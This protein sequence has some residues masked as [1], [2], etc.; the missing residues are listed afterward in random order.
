MNNDV[1]E[2]KSR[3]NLVDVVGDYVRLER[4]G[5]GQWKGLC[6]FHKERTPSFTVS[7]E[8]QLW[9]CFGCGK[10]GD[11]FSFVMEQE[12]VDF[13]E[14]LTLLAQRA[15][16]TLSRQHGGDSDTAPADKKKTYFD[17]LELATK[18]YQKQL[19]DGI[20]ARQARPYVVE[21][22]INEMSMAHFRLGFAPEGWRHIT[23]FLTSRGY[24]LADIAATGL[25]VRKD[26]TQGTRHSDY[27]D[28]FRNRIMFPITDPMG[29]VIGFSARIVPSAADAQG[30][31]AVAKYINTSESPVYHKSSVLYGIAQAKQAMKD[32]KRAVVV[33]GNMD[34]IAAHQ[35]GIAETVAVSGTALTEQHARIIRRYAPE[36]VLFFDNDTAGRAAAVK[37]T[38]TCVAV[39]LA[40]KMVT[41]EGDAKD[42]ADIARDDPDAL[43]RLVQSARNA[44]EVLFAQAR[45]T[46]DV[47][48]PDARSAL[49]RALAPLVAAHESRVDREYWAQQLAQHAQI[50]LTAAQEAVEHAR[51]DAQPR[52]RAVA[53]EE[54]DGAQGQAQTPQHTNRS[55]ALL[56]RVLSLAAQSDRAFAALLEQDIPVQFLTEHAALHA[57]M[58]AGATGASSY[59]SALSTIDD[60]TIAAALAHVMQTHNAEATEMVATATPEDLIK[61]VASL[62]R[63]M[64]DAWHKEQRTR[65]IAE[66][67]QAEA[68]G[69]HQRQKEIL[70][71]IQALMT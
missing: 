37:S 50:S 31:R 38:M 12:G 2:V 35:A 34:V 8:R 33:E 26:G 40:V 41:V 23:E 45:A 21:R 3:L 56:A 71:R 39:G 32:T 43:V 63:L 1:E 22:G 58:M 61:E 42:A 57:L 15:G 55:E 47:T 62:V 16:V 4:A 52:A 14:A 17:I 20:G 53:T 48:D 30:E 28:R 67:A 27:Y 18:F 29:H 11:V 59:A 64:V 60:R 51:T 44:L 25:I 13:R 10:G 19:T 69:D 7:E 68:A 6:P 46:H 36:V 5:T 49:V 54:R 24:A 66:L 9:H 65:L 70:S